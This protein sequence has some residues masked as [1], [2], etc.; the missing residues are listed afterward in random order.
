MYKSSDKP[1]KESDWDGS[2]EIHDRYFEVANTK[3]Y[4]ENTDFY[5][6]ISEMKTT[7]IRH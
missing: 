4:I 6:R 5:S 2:M 7:M 1:I 3:V